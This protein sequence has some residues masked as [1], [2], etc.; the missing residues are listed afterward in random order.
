MNIFEFRPVSRLKSLVDSS[1]PGLC[2]TKPV[3]KMPLAKSD[4]TSNAMPKPTNKDRLCERSEPQS[5]P[6]VGRAW[7]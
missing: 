2:T 5:Y 7:Q 4:I 6:V 1:P 3:K